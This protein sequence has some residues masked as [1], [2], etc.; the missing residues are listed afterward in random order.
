MPCPSHPL[1]LVL[2]IAHIEKLLRQNCR[3]KQDTCFLYFIQLS[4]AQPDNF[5][6][7]IFSLSFVYN[8]GFFL[9]SVIKSS[10]SRHFSIWTQYQ[11]PSTHVHCRLTG[12]ICVFSAQ[13][14]QVTRLCSEYFETPYTVSLSGELMLE[15]ATL[16]SATSAGQAWAL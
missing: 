7:S 14:S 4:F 16:E 3:C 15:E 13:R 2:N 10:F 12:M 5:Y 11:I 6:T 1:C 9:P 8:V